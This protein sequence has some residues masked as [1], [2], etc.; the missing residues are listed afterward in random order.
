MFNILKLSLLIC[1]LLL[2]SG[3]GGASKKTDCEQ[4]NW[5]ESGQQDAISGNASMLDQYEKTCSEFGIRPNVGSYEQGYQTGLAT[6]CQPDSAYAY[7]VSGKT[8]AGICSPALE[9]AF[10]R[11]YIEGLKK[12]IEDT[13]LTL[14]LKEL[15]LRNTQSR[16]SRVT[17]KKELSKLRKKVE[18]YKQTVEGLRKE[19]DGSYRMIEKFRYQLERTPEG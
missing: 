18:E 5:L 12:Y 4:K 7:G 15:G 2:I 6:F 17:D 1:G 14:S 11:K 16:Q 19:I 3:C 10:L 13:R 8:Y 9:A